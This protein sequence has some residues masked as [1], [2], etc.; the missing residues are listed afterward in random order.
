MA[1]FG[2]ALSVRKSPSRQYNRRLKG[3]EGASGPTMKLGTIIGMVGLIVSIIS[4]AA[5]AAEP[6]TTVAPVPSPATTAT[7]GAAPATSYKIE[8]IKKRFLL[9]HSS[10]VYEKADKASAVI[11]QVHQGKHETVTGL[12][13][14]WLRI[15]LSKGKVG[16]I[17]SSAAE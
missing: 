9:T 12:T 6:S 14:D 16:F 3:Q 15:Q 10:S 17:P 2:G 4:S 13:G 5:F 8:A 11:G 1:G 7:P